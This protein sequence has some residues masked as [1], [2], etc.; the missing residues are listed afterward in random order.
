MII[1]Y[2][3]L[4]EFFIEKI[5]SL[6]KIKDDT[7]AYITSTFIKYKDSKYDLSK[8]S[9]TIEY[10]KAK[11]TG[12][13]ELY[14]NLGDWILWIES[15][16]PAALKDATNEYYYTLG[17]QSFHRCFILT[18]RTWKVFEEIADTLPYIITHL[19][20]ELQTSLLLSP[21]MET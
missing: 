20:A 14:Q 7:R 1:K 19:H 8:E 3:T 5:K 12:S 21:L 16:Y 17:Q 6:P 4:D 10:A 9:L 13:F 18:N 11:F 2:S 15:T